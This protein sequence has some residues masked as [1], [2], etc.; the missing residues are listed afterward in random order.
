MID[1]TN[2]MNEERKKLYILKDH[3]KRPSEATTDQ[4]HAY[5]RCENP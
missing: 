5:K 1:K 4:W 2:R 3:E